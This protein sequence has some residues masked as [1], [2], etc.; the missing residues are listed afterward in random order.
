MTVSWLVMLMSCCCCV[1]E[2][3]WRSHSAELCTLSLKLYAYNGS[4]HAGSQ[5]REN[6]LC[7]LLP[8][9]RHTHTQPFYGP[10]SMTTGASQCQKKKSGARKITKADTPTICLGATP[11]RLI[12]DLPPS[13]PI[14]TPDALPAAILPV[15]PG[16]GQAPNMLACISGG[17]W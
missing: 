12:S 7:M 8:V 11:S 3:G 15:Y 17:V 14:F 6:R 9:I 1:F 4:R 5:H 2:A 13:S 16:L 10:F